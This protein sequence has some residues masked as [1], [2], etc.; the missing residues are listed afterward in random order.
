MQ[1][2]EGDEGLLSGQIRSEARRFTKEEERGNGVT[3]GDQV[4]F[5]GWR[6][7]FFIVGPLRSQPSFTSNQVRVSYLQRF[8]INS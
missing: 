4:E 7:R 5:L 3:G 2:G 1:C 6:Q 8:L